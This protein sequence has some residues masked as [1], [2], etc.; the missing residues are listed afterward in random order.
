MKILALALIV[1]GLTGLAVGTISFTTRD[2]VVD[3]GPID[4]TREETHSRT[5][6]VG[7]SLAAI[8]VGTVL[9]LAG[10]HRTA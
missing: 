8:A 1:A 7:A 10:R 4:V 3:L 9:L 2:E 6:P 5:I